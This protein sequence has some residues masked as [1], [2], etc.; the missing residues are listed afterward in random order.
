[1]L[2]RLTSLQQLTMMGCNMQCLPPALAHL[3]S[4]RVLYL[5]GWLRQSSQSMGRASAW[6]PGLLLLLLL[7]QPGE[8]CQDL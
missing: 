3:K 7:G 5:G 1:M 6:G 8:G 4:L 2:S